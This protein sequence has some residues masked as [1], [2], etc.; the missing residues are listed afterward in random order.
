MTNLEVAQ[1]Y[2]GN[3]IAYGKSGDLKTVMRNLEYIKELLGPVG[4]LKTVMQENPNHDWDEF[5]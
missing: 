2:I 1:C 4:D 5:K 3:A